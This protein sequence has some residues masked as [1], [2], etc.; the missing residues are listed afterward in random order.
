MGLNNL[1]WKE[2]MDLSVIIPFKLSFIFKI[3]LKNNK[4]RISCY[5]TLWHYL[6]KK[7]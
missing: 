5:S 4:E 7:R 2:P 3:K 6:K 1:F